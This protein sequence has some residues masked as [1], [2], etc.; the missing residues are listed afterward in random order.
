MKSPLACRQIDHYV[1]CEYCLTYNDI[2]FGNP[3]MMKKIVIHKPGSYQQLQIEEFT[4][5]PPGPDE[6][7][8]E[9][10]ACGINFADCCVRMGVYSSAKKYVGWPITPGFEVSGLIKAIGSNVT[11]LFVGQRVVAITRFGGYTSHLNVPAA[12][13]FS[14]PESLSEEQGAA[15][16]AVF[17]TAYYAMHELAH[18]RKGSCLLIHSAAGGVGSALVQLG[19]LAQCTVVGVVGSS[20]KIEAVKSLN[21]DDVIDKSTHPLWS[22]AEEISPSG[23]DAIFDANGPETLKQSYEHLSPGG[24]LVVY[25]F[26]TMLSKGS[27][28]VNWL[29]ALWGYLKTPCFN[30]LNM[31]GDNHSVLAFN[32]SYL[33][34]QNDRIQESMHHILA[35]FD[36]GL[37]TPPAF[38]AY[39]MEQVQDAHRALESGQTVGKLVLKF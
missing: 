13:V 15:I 8:I 26:H 3:D 1:D 12:Q 33:F 9:T 29:K 11:S 39:P 35:L 19:K 18:P 4:L 22:A 36:K 30:P 20:H 2:F 21:A 17:L 10:K 32:L 16:P 34:D 24:K 28:R 31:T 14:L 37:L 27:G 38:T 6:V 25:G 23:F 7:L 5:A